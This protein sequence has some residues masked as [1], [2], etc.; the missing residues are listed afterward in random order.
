LIYLSLRR[1][2]VSSR[3]EHEDDPIV[4]DEGST[5]TSEHAWDEER[6]LDERNDTALLTLP[7]NLLIL[8]AKTN[9]RKKQL[10]ENRD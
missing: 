6:L 5:S 7:M 3:A 9:T 10:V 2:K 4:G 1:V 8:P